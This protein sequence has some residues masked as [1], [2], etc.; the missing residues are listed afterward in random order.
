LDAVDRIT[1]LVEGQRDDTDPQI[2]RLSAELADSMEEGKRELSMSND[3]FLEAS[4]LLLTFL[5]NVGMYPTDDKYRSVNTKHAR[6]EK[7]APFLR[8]GL[9]L[10]GFVEEGDF[11]VLKGDSVKKEV[12][13]T[14]KLLQ[15]A[16]MFDVVKRV[17]RGGPAPR[18][19]SNAGGSGSGPAGNVS[20]SQLS[21]VLNSLM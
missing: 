8:K 3:A 17:G 6:F 12:I 7:H 9:Q 13:K 18:Q 4:K 2:P 14:A 5:R 1:E 15:K 11:L 21:N 20:S 16:M 19:G 10:C